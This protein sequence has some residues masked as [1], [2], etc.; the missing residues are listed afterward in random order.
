MNGKHQL[1]PEG[2][3]KYKKELEYLIKNGQDHRI[4]EGSAG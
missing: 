3:E 2:L 4:T 1:T